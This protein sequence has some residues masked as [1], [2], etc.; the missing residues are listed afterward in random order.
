M[1]S[2]QQSELKA[3]STAGLS[4]GTLRG[5]VLVQYA[6]SLIG[7]NFRAIIQVAPIMLH[8][9]LPVHIYEAWLTLTWVALLVF[10]HEIEDMDKFCAI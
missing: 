6:G 10:Q 2:A 4:F 3:L 8:N 5:K 7:C 1:S 9:L